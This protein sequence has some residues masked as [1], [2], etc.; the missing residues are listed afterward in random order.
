M[1]SDRAH[2]LLSPKTR[3][4]LLQVI[5]ETDHRYLFI[6]IISSQL[7]EATALTQEE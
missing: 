7:S 3:K 2:K 1:G 6:P 5:N 4:E